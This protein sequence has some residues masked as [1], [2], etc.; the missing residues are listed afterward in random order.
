MQRARNIVT[1]SVITEIIRE[2]PQGHTELQHYVR[3]H[4]VAF[5][6]TRSRVS[7]SY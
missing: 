1:D 3:H 4:V 7:F 2:D 6:S 5:L